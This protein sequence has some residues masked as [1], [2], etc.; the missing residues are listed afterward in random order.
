MN[1]GSWWCLDVLAICYAAGGDLERATGC[2][3]AGQ[4]GRAAEVQ[5]LL[6]E[7]IATFKRKEVPTASVGDL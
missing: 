7:R 4:N 2:I 6:D 1:W 3:R 5:S